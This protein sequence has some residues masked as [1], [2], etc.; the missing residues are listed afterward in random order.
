MKISVMIISLLTKRYIHMKFLIAL[1]MQHWP[2]S[3]KKAVMQILKV[4]STHLPRKT[5]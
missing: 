4:L 3:G 2:W 1:I 5:K